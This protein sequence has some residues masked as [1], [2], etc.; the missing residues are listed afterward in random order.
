VAAA[1][2]WAAQAQLDPHDAPTFQREP[3]Q[4]T[5]ARLLLAQGKWEEAL[6]LLGRLGRAAE[7]A[8]RLSTFIETLLLQA[9]AFETQ[10][11]SAQASSALERSLALTEPGGYVRIFLDEAAPVASLLRRMEQRSIAPQ[12][13]ETLLAAFD[14]SETGNQ[15]DS[16]PAVR[17]RASSARI[18]GLI[19]PLSE[20]EL[21]VLQ[22]IVA[23]KSNRE[24]A[25]ELIVTLGTVKK[26]I[27]NIFGKLAVHS[28]TQAV[29]RA[30]ERDL[31]P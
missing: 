21:E 15:V 11:D 31:I 16:V 17:T 8:R 6:S 24:I 23:G 4:I 29:A 2:Q 3:E 19:E 13:V 28:R 25:R 7:A 20:R 22:L 10:N 27:N 18:Q 1:A 5:L 14:A 9:L 12:Y 30:R 26:H